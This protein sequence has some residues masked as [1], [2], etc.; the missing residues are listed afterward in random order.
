MTVAL[1]AR[2]SIAGL[3]G[4]V[5]SACGGPGAGARSPSNDYPPPAAETSDGEVVGADRV[6]P[7]QKLA[8]SPKLGSEGM[9]PAAT[10]ATAEPGKTQKPPAK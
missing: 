6:P 8:E 5:L 4:L 9:K 1:W 10:P 2:V 7:N 3:F